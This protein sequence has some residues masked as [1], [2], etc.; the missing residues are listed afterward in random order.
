MST[1]VVASLAVVAEDTLAANGFL[2]RFRFGISV[3]LAMQD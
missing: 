1:A 2:M 3:K